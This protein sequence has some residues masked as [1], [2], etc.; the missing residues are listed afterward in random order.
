[1]I[2]IGPSR[3]LWGMACP[4]SSCSSVGRLSWPDLSLGR[5]ITRV[6]PVS[7]LKASRIFAI[8]DITWCT[9]QFFTNFKT[10]KKFFLSS[11]LAAGIFTFIVSAA[12]LVTIPPA[13]TFSNQ[14][15]EF[16]ALFPV[17]ILYISV[18]WLFLC[19]SYPKLGSISV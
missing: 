7:L 4:V 10:L 12:C 14:T 6:S 8:S 11:S 17:T 18:I 5:L 9:V 3:P 1:M 2:P 15:E 16:T 19:L 13:L